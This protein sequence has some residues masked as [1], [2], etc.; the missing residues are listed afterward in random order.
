MM[1]NQMFCA[2]VTMDSPLKKSLQEVK[3]EQKLAETEEIRKMAADAEKSGKTSEYIVQAENVK[4]WNLVM[5][6]KQQ[7]IVEEENTEELKEQQ[8]LVLELTEKEAQVLSENKD[9]AFV[10][11]NVLFTASSNEGKKNSDNSRVN[12]IHKN[13]KALKKNLKQKGTDSREQQWYLDAIHLPKK[14]KGK[15]RIRVAVLDSG[16]S[17]STDIDVKKHMCINEEH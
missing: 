14:K 3:A 9:V 1:C 7:D 10:E 11:E 17:F 16:I 2:G 6:E 13:K 8:M 12:T 5:E 15:D 4:T